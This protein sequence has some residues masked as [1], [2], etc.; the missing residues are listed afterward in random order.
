ML[1]TIKSWLKQ[2]TEVGLLLIAAAVVL[3]II[4]GSAVPFIGVGI[5]DN[6]IA[7]TA[8][9]GQDGLI[10]IIAIGIIVWLYLRK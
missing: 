9:L 10:G 1:D 6:I 4:F 8:K 5:L 3:E 7:I 2:I